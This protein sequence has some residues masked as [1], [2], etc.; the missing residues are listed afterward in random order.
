MYTNI[1]KNK[2]YYRTFWYAHTGSLEWLCCQAE[3]KHELGVK[4]YVKLI[5]SMDQP[6][7]STVTGQGWKHKKITLLAVKKD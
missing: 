7:K 4:V 1:K 2:D 6:V 3:Q 5:T